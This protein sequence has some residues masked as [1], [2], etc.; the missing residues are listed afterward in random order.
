MVAGG[1]CWGG[2]AEAVVVVRGVAVARAAGV[3]VA[4]ADVVVACSGKAPAAPAGWGA[5]GPGAVPAVLG[6]AAG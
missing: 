2:A 1:V 4:A 6:D 5:D 3:A